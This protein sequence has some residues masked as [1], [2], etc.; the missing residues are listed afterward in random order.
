MTNAVRLIVGIRRKML[1]SVS[2][3][4]AKTG[5][6]PRAVCIEHQLIESFCSTLLG[7]S[8]D[9][10]FTVS[11]RRSSSILSAMR[12]LCLVHSAITLSKS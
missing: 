11:L 3:L 4:E 9:N 5:S 2:M 8:L 12:S 6:R 1:H 10:V 7:S